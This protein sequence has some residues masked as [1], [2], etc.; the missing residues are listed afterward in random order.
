VVADV[1]LGGQRRREG[2]ELLDELDDRERGRVGLGEQ[3]R[4]VGPVVGAVDD[5]DPRGLV[6]D[7]RAVLLRE[8][9]ADDDGEVL[10]GRAALVLEDLRWP[11][12]P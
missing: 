3:L 8:A 9:A 6:G 11:R 10:A 12:V 2:L 7:G 5:V 1:A 4:Q